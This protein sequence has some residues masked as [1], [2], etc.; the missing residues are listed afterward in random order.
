MTGK[1]RIFATFLQIIFMN[2]KYF[3][4]VLLFKRCSKKKFKIVKERGEKSK[5]R[6]KIFFLPY[7]KVH[8]IQKTQSILV[9]RQDGVC[10]CGVVAFADIQLKLYRVLGLM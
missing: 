8:L 3:R 7:F 2:M 1:A 5:I 9:F 4:E 6:A 10:R